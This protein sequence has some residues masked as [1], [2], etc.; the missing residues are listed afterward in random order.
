MFMQLLLVPAVGLS[1]SI[2]PS[3]TTSLNISWILVDDFVT[4]TYS[5]ADT[6]CF[7]TTSLLVR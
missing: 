2:V 4:S 7:I 5:D 6:D 3:S 1:V